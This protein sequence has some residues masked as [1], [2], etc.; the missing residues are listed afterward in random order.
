[1]LTTVTLNRIESK[2]Y[3]LMKT[4]NAMG[5]YGNGFEEKTWGYCEDFTKK[6]FLRIRDNT[7]GLEKSFYTESETTEE[8][9]TNYLHYETINRVEKVLYEVE[10]MTKEVKKRYKKCGKARC[11]TA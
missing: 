2:S 1:M 8:I 11:K 5:Y 6:D 4:L 10:R 7:V 3:E 9:G